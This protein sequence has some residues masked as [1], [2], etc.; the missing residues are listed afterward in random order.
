MNVRFVE[1][2]EHAGTDVLE[3][4][5]DTMFGMWAVIDRLDEG[6]VRVRCCGCDTVADKRWANLRHDHN[7]PPCECVWRPYSHNL[8]QR[9][10]RFFSFHRGSRPIGFESP[11][12]MATHLVMALGV[13]PKGKHIILVD[14]ELGLV[15]GNFRYE[16]PQRLI[17]K[18]KKKRE[19]PESPDRIYLRMINANRGT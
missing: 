11:R 17:K 14:K 6:K 19:R 10:Q 12:D 3:A 15:P 16:K 4:Q 8:L 5:D 9:C 13:P 2:Y 7:I 18:V 1:S